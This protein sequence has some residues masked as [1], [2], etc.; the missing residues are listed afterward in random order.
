LS[1]DITKNYVFVNN[2]KKAY[3]IFTGK[4]KFFNLDEGSNWHTLFKR[5]IKTNHTAYE[6]FHFI[7]HHYK[8]S[9]CNSAMIA[10]DNLVTSDK[11]WSAFLKYQSGLRKRISIAAKDQRS[12]LITQI[13]KMKN[14]NT[15]AE[16]LLSPDIPASAAII[17]DTALLFQKEKGINIDKVIDKFLSEAVFVIY[18]VPAFLDNCR[19]L[20]HYL[21]LKKLI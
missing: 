7:I 5:L 2:F 1:T 16:Y 9:T 10:H 18:C 14:L 20:K 8:N 4:K 15:I 21:D 19:Y 6:F 11:V 12:H 13:E 3:K 17:L